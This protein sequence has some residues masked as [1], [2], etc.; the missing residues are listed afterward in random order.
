MAKIDSELVSL[1]FN[2]SRMGRKREDRNNNLEYQKGDILTLKGVEC[3]DFQMPSKVYEV[4]KNITSFSDIIMDA[5]VVKQIEGKQSAI[6]SLTKHDCASLG[7]DFQPQL[8]LMPKNLNWECSTKKLLKKEFD[9]NDFSTYPVVPHSNMIE[10]IVLEISG[11]SRMDGYG[12]LYRIGEMTNLSNDIIENGVYITSK[13]NSNKCYYG[14]EVTHLLHPMWDDHI[15]FNGTACYEFSI[16]PID[17]TQV[18]GRKFTDIFDVNIKNNTFRVKNVKVS[19]Y[20]GSVY[21]NS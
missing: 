1:Y 21:I 7:I 6:F 20:N 3:D 17:P 5:Y 4:I 19:F 10:K 13:V 9:K 11:I 18:I 2:P 12:S 16:P 15:S 14:K 8:Q